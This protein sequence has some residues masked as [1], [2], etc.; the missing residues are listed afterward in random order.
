ML[1]SA[2]EVDI[3]SWRDKKC[4]TVSR[5]TSFVE[6][7]V[8]AYLWNP[9][10][11]EIEQRY[12]Y[13][14]DVETEVL[15]PVL[16]LVG[17][18][19]KDGGYVLR[20]A[21]ERGSS[22]LEEG[23]MEAEVTHAWFETR[24]EPSAKY[25]QA[26][27]VRWSL[28]D[29]AERVAEGYTPLLWSRFRGQVKYIDGRWRS[30]HIDMRPVTWGGIST[31]FT[32]PVADDGSFDALVPARVYGVLNV[33]G[34][35]YGYDAFERWAWDYDLT[36]DREDEFTLGRVELYGMRAFDTNGGPQTLFVIF[37]PTG[38][39]RILRFDEDRD[40]FVKGHEKEKLD[41]AMKESPTVIGTELTR[42][43]VTIWYN[44]MEREIVQFDLIPEYC[45]SG[46]QVQ[47]LAQITLDERPA[48]GMWNEIKVEVRS[49]ERLH[50][51]EVVD[52]GQ[53]SVGFCRP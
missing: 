11:D 44:G 40:G 49:K 33:N 14:A 26:E 10:V 45:G 22:C 19:F 1:C 28:H 32:L 27:R 24:V 17:N 4:Y 41:A 12:P 31:N 7:V 21:I 15:K 53:G 46:W 34:T 2:Q 18:G 48:R 35:G 43:E 16:V 23:E 50:G 39:S 3:M 38:L 52:F 9:P 6:P 8:T 37:R 20:Y 42:D 36:R 25:P 5:Y 47:Y 29:D 51:E 13:K 30:T